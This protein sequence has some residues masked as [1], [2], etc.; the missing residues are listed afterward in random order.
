M[1][2]SKQFW[3]AV[4]RGAFWAA[5]KVLR[6][7][8]WKPALAWG[9]AMGTFGYY[10]SGRFRAVADKNLQIAYGDSLTDRERQH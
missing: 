7:V 10:V 9:T 3:Q 6:H 1:R 5:F 2:K 4:V 8:P